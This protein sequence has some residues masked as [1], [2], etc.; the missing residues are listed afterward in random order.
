MTEDEAIRHVCAT[1]DCGEAEA[2]AYLRHIRTEAPYAIMHRYPAA[3][4]GVTW[5]GVPETPLQYD[6][7]TILS[8]C[9]MPIPE[10]TAPSNVATAVL[11]STTG[12]QA[13]PSPI[14]TESAN[15]VSKTDAVAGV[16]RRVPFARNLLR[17]QYRVRVVRWQS[18]GEQFKPPSPDADRK[19]AD[20]HYVGVPRTA[21]REARK[22]LA[23][24][25][26]KKRGKRSG[27]NWHE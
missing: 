9:P 25:S 14:P 12:D 11:R 15:L 8:Y 7:A 16:G 24:E 13:P 10:Q 3:G 4:T 1:D 27:A 19:W 26:W 5:P 17:A 6:R 22:D 18:T 2:R 20:S 23:P 21:L